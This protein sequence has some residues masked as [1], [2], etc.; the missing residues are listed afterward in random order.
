MKLLS[1]GQRGVARV[2]LSSSDTKRRRLGRRQDFLAR[3]GEGFVPTHDAEK[4][5][6]LH[7][8]LVS[9]DVHSTNT[10]PVAA[11]RGHHSLATVPRRTPIE[12]LLIWVISDP[13]TIAASTIAPWWIPPET[14]IQPEAMVINRQGE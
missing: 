9:K 14:G 1:D 4:E 12:A 11:T 3:H 6:T 2:D 7:A 10:P 5:P 8:G 13:A